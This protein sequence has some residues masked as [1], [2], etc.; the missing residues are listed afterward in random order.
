M[1]HRF[2]FAMALVL[3]SSCAV[4]R[5]VPDGGAAERADLPPMRSFPSAAAA[6]P[7]RSN[8][9]I[10]RDFLD[11]S[12]QLES[13]RKLPRFTRF[14]GPISLRVLGPA[15]ARLEADLAQLLARLRN[16]AGIDIRRVAAE[17]AANVTVQ[18]VP[19]ATLQRNVP[20]AAC[21]VVPR[22]TDWR[23]FLRNR[24]GPA[25]DWAT[26]ERRE[27]LT[28]F[29]PGDVAPQE[30]RDCLHEELAQALGPLNDLYRLPDSVFND[31][32]FH[33][34]LTGFDMLILRATYAPEL[35]SGMSPA[36]V[37][38]ALPRLLERLNPGGA[39]SMP[40]PR[41]ATP[42]DWSEAIERA[43]GPGASMARRRAAAA[44]AVGIARA[45]GWEDNRL[46]FSYFALGRLSLGD[47]PDLALGAFLRAAE[48]YGRDPA[49]RVHGAHI[50]MQLAAF[51]LSAG[52]PESAIAIVDANTDAVIAGQNAALLSALLLVKSEALRDTGRAAA[53][54]RLRAEALGWARYGF[55]EGAELRRRVA[56]I[57]AIAPNRR[58]AGS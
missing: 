28:I 35:R 20:A 23:D 11:L 7:G 26:L 58:N 39:R 56:E 51:A 47:A 38:R 25:V 29:I 19:R 5:A 42:L 10:A 48:I 46:A 40:G 18:V 12:F 43:L 33:T 24:R 22:V 17:S 44:R 1:T 21:F 14:E 55:G 49:T 45:R 34:V 31:D 13:G 41:E 32:N 57:G 15:P 9:E 2:L 8:A 54:R 16:E 53:A 30:V 6:P 37:A 3:L 36:E 4:P 27:R 50:A 52:Q